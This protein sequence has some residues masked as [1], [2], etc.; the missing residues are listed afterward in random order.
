MNS[1]FLRCL[2]WR[3]ADQ[4]RREGRGNKKYSSRERESLSSSLINRYGT[5]LDRYQFIES[6]RRGEERNEPIR[7]REEN[8]VPRV[9]EVIVNFTVSRPWSTEETKNSLEQ[10]IDIRP[11]FLGLVGFMGEALSII[12]RSCNAPAGKTARAS[13]LSNSGWAHSEIAFSDQ[14]L[15]EERW[16]L[17]SAT[18]VADKHKSRQSRDE[19]KKKR[20][21][22]KGK[23]R[24][25]I[26][27]LVVRN[28]AKNAWRSAL[29]TRYCT[30]VNCW[31]LKQRGRNFVEQETMKLQ[32]RREK[33][34]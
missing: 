16:S 24:A 17:H 19:G 3:D 8:L 31:M 22:W 30:S 12:H 26:L 21:I 4:E 11:R 13:T 15:L 27:E 7:V 1:P 10:L 5:T 14:L 6:R 32:K 25:E 28:N 9:I 23:K 34:K 33:K 18:F 20:K 2:S 29:N